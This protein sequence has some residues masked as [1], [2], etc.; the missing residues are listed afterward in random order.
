VP[1]LLAEI[2]YESA[3]RA[4][5]QQEAA[6]NELRDRT[7][8]LLAAEALTTSFLGAAAIQ[9]GALALPGRLAIASFAVSLCIALCVLLPWR[10]LRFSLSGH[11]LYEGLQAYGEDEEEIYRRT[12]YWLQVLWSRN[13]AVMARLYP[14]F[15]TSIAVLAVELV[16]WTIALRD[17]I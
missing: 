4:L 17:I 2:A 10:G 13:E 11:R 9:R 5:G 1:H 7:G 14:L 6:L 16:L 3:V 8:T 15:T 12:A